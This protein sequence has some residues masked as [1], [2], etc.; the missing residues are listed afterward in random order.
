MLSSLYTLHFGLHR[1]LHRILSSSPIEGWVS[2][3]DHDLCTVS[4]SMWEHQP[5]ASKWSENEV[6]WKPRHHL[7]QQKGYYTKVFKVKIYFYRLLYKLYVDCRPVSCFSDLDCPNS[8]RPVFS[9][10]ALWEHICCSLLY[11]VS[12]DSWSFLAIFCNMHKVLRIIR[13]D[14]CNKI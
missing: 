1:L 3:V 13:K 2:W 8:I 4:L 7:H 5:W 10:K 11:T 14:V 6:S 12:A 9:L